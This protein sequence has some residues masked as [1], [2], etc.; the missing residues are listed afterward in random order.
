MTTARDLSHPNQRIKASNKLSQR[1]FNGENW[2]LALDACPAL[3]RDVFIALENMGRKLSL[4]L[5]DWCRRRYGV[6]D[7]TIGRDLTLKTRAEHGE[8]YCKILVT[9]DSEGRVSCDLWDSMN[10]DLN[11]VC[12]LEMIGKLTTNLPRDSQMTIK[13]EWHDAI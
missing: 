6:A 11:T 12:A 5:F 2:T 4:V 10:L 8:W 7:T 9:S 3:Q 1:L 13:W